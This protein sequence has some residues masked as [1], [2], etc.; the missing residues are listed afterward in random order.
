MPRRHAVRPV[1]LPASEPTTANGHPQSHPDNDPMS[2]LRYEPLPDLDPDQARQ[3]LSA[4]TT[5]VVA[6]TKKLPARLRPKTTKHK[7]I[8]RID[9]PAKR[10]FGY[11]VRVIWNKQRRSKF[12][13]DS[14]YGDRLAALAAAI[15]WRNATERELGKPR[16]ERQVI[17][18]AR[19]ST[20]IV[21]VR[22]TIKDGREVYE[23][24]WRDGNRIRRTSYSI[25][26]HGER[27]ALAL[28]RRAR[29][30]YE[31]QRQ[32]TPAAD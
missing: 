22:R 31:R 30:K 27:R 16:T 3:L 17:G 7:G 20:G 18:V 23:A 25:A 5:P 4:P 10:T 2:V 28:A 13:S 11:F 1:N 32:R 6:D 14:V 19:T 15:E 29:E 24:T 9:H 12:F 21:G 8:T 26:K